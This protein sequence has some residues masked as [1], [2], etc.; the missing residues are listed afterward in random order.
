MIASLVAHA[1]KARRWLIVAAIPA[2]TLAVLALWPHAAAPWSP[3][4]T[5]TDR[6]PQVGIRATGPA[7][8]PATAVA[9]AVVGMGEG[10][11]PKELEV[12]IPEGDVFDLGDIHVERSL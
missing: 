1:L 7:L 11:K 2:C 10:F 3:N 6:L 5:P 12:D 4:D 8:P 9:P